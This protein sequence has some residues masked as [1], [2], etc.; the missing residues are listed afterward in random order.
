MN[1]H[2]LICCLMIKW[3][4]NRRIHWSRSFKPAHP[5]LLRETQTGVYG[6]FVLL[7]PPSQV[8]SGAALFTQSSA[9]LIKPWREARE[10]RRR[11]TQA[12]YDVDFWFRPQL[13]HEPHQFS[14]A[15]R[16]RTAQCS[17]CSIPHNQRCLLQ[18]ILRP[19]H[20]KQPDVWEAEAQGFLKNFL[21]A[22][23]AFGAFL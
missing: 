15:N 14:A 19:L 16:Q 23:C 20:T 2:S 17:S 10:G 7:E 13:P 6:E 21:C 18:T 5:P 1:S 11:Q 12:G 8:C 4:E 9:A 3:Q 22:F